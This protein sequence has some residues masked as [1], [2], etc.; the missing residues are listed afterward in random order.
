M[1]HQLKE[2]IS[3]MDAT[4]QQDLLERERTITST[5]ERGFYAITI[6]TVLMLF[7]IVVQILVIRKDSRKRQYYRKIF[8]L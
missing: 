2:I 5:R 8:G 7:V 4:I 3:Q 1:N 6:A